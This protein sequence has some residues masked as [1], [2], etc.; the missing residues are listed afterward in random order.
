MAQANDLGLFKSASR[1]RLGGGFVPEQGDSIGS[2]PAPPRAARAIKPILLR[3]VLG[4]VV[5]LATRGLV[6]SDS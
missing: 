3:R 4:C 5:L 6:G 1:K 2:H